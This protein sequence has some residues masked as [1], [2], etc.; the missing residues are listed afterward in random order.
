MTQMGLVVIGR[1][2]GDRLRRCLQSVLE[3]VDQL[4]YV[5]SGSTDGSIEF[6]RSLG[7]NVVELDLSIPFTAA[8]A[9]NAGFERLLEI[10]PEIQWVQFV[11]GD[12]E[13]D[14]NWIEQGKAELMAN[15]KLAGV[16]GRSRERFPHHS[17]YNK[18]FDI[19]WGMPPG[20]V[21][22]CTGNLMMRVEAL[23]DVGHFNPTLIAGEEPELC[24]RL[25]QKGWKVVRI[26]APMILHDAEM[27]HWRQWWK[28][29][30]RAGHA[31]AEVSR[32]CAH[33]PE[34]FWMKESLSIWL[35]GLIV[36]LLALTLAVPTQGWSLLLFLLYP[37]LLYRTYQSMSGQGLS[38]ADA[39]LYT[40]SCVIGKFPQVQ[41]QLQ[42]Y[43]NRFW[44]KKTKL[45]EYKDVSVMNNPSLQAGQ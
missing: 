26:H 2:E 34:R 6:A 5:D 40:L 19:E 21:K 43:W 41:G 36:P 23:Q 27:T 33:T 11:D 12:C 16:C 25:R 30:V 44:G 7:V 31:Y 10:D 8:R 13:V 24:C 22:T 32:L 42:F 18:L 9:R 45:I 15:P 3:Q 17:I 37:R 14:S 38:S 39:R 1:N 35:W 28:R 4:V 20:E 29:M